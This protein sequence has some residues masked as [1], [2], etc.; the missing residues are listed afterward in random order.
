MKVALIC[1]MNNGFFSLVR[2]LRDRGID[3]DLLIMKYEFEHFSP[4]ADSYDDSYLDYT[5]RLSWGKHNF[6]D[7]SSKVI[8]DDVKRYDVIIGCGSTP[9]YLNKINRSLDI[10]IPYG[11][12]I[13]EMPFFRLNKLENYYRIYQTYIRNKNQRI[14][15]QN[16]RYICIG[17][18]SPEFEQV[19]KKINY[20]GNLVK[21]HYPAV[22]NKFYN[23]EEIQ[24]YYKNSEFYNKFKKIR[25]DYELVIFHHTRHLWKNV[26]NVWSYKGNEIL[27]TGFANYLN[28]KDALNSCLVL[29][30]YGPDVKASKKLI[31]SYGIEKNVKWFPK[32]YRKDLMI[33]VSLSDIGAYE[34][35]KSW[36]TGGVLF[37]FLVMG[38][39][40]LQ[41]REDKMY[42]NDFPELYPILNVKTAENITNAFID[43]AKNPDVYRAQGELGREWYQKHVVEHSV[44]EYM[45]I[46]DNS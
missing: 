17:G 9:A 18:T 45:K 19:F 29:F 20:H 2:Y 41:Y 3:A 24:K 12:D 34:F 8:E 4:K 40:I 6:L 43:Y 36:L 42:E 7:V 33:G 13:Y 28:R 14:G 15:I 32:L 21:I 31:R 38:K 35:G 16:S 39:P 22:Y 44:S 46:I 27:I 1:N 30:D 37:E 11:S 23:P 26:P 10:F 25:D 5:K